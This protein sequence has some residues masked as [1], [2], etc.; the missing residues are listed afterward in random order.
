MLMRHGAFALLPCRPA[1]GL[2]LKPQWRYNYQWP[3]QN[4]GTS[5]LTEDQMSDTFSDIGRW[6][7]CFSAGG[8]KRCCGVCTAALPRAASSPL[9]CS[10]SGCRDESGFWHPFHAFFYS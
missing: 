7:S 2:G 6:V 9:Y 10:A 3:F 8:P 1:Q 4:I 5:V